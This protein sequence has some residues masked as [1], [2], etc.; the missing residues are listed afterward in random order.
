M[1]SANKVVTDQQL[2]CTREIAIVLVFLLSTCVCFVTLNR[3]FYFDTVVIQ[4]IQIQPLRVPS[5]YDYH[6]DTQVPVATGYIEWTGRYSRQTDKIKQQIQKEK[7]IQLTPP[8]TL[9]QN[10]KNKTKYIREIID[11]TQKTH[12]KDETYERKKK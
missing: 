11:S 3:S 8:P 12:E 2:D 5:F 7:Q 10:F 4:Y 9:P 6:R 1:L